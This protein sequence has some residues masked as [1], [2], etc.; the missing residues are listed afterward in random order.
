MKSSLFFKPRLLTPGPSPVPDFVVS[1]MQTGLYYHRSPEFA[2]I[3]KECRQMLGQVFATKQEV[4]MLTGSGTLAM[5]ASI[6]SLFNEGDLVIAINSG[7]F[8]ARWIDQAKVYGLKVVELK[9]A[10]GSAVKI[11]DVE[12]AAKNHP[13]AKGILVHASET[14]TSVR[15]DIKSI[16]KVAHSLKDCLM[17]VDGITAVGIVAVPMD[18]WGIDV[19]CSGSQKGFML[20]PGLSLIALSDRAWNR[21]SQVQVKG[22]YMDLRKE[23]KAQAEGSTAFT[24]AVTLIAGLHASLKFITDF[25]VDDFFEARW[26]MVFAAR[27]AIRSMGLKLFVD[28]DSDC[29]PSCTAVLTEGL[30]ANK[31]LKTNFGL[32][33]AGGQD[34]L[35]GKIV[36]IG[37]LGYMDAWDVLNQLVA[38]AWVFEAKGKKVDLPAGIAAFK[39]EIDLATSR[40]PENW[41]V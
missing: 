4:L 7:K 25:G 22:Y 11:K 28:H 29:S 10:A 23:R 27:A 41:R 8:G 18:A 33:V 31:D 17:V 13:D 38:L 32:T 3:V 5:E 30:I 39:A 24:G 19:L 14:S 26:K 36:R 20:P 35:K 37:H 34:D 16:S 6:V 2:G 40:V 15:H 12:D 1:A 9:V 21:T